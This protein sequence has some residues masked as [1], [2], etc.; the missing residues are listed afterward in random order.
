MLLTILAAAA[1]GDGVIAIHNGAV[2]GCADAITACGDPI[3]AVFQIDKTQLRI[4]AVFGM[5]AVLPGDDIEGAG[6]NAHF[7]LSAQTMAGDIHGIAAPGN[8]KGVLGHDAVTAG[9]G[10]GKRTGSIQGQ[11]ILGKDDSANVGM[12]RRLL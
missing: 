12:G 6:C 9:A 1:G 10:D 8:P 2:S 7:V 11:I 3:S 5:D 4:L